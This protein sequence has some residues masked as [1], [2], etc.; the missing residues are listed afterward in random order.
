M[1]QLRFATALIASIWCIS[2]TSAT[3]L[4]IAFQ[5]RDPGVKRW[6]W[7]Q[8][9]GPRNSP[10]TIVYFS[11]QHFKTILGEYLVVLPP[12][13]YDIISSYTQARIARPDCP[14]SFAG[15]DVWY[16][17]QIAD[18]DKARTRECILPQRAACDY[19]SGVVKLRGIDWTAK[20][21][22]PLV[23]FMDQIKCKISAE[24]RS[25]AGFGR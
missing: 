11:T 16:T 12:A 7:Y 6:M 19:L 9:L 10:F 20:E 18:H 8:V 3:E 23:D 25:R 22:R 14:G 21:L 4:P 1:T 13:R 24:E 15:G 2:T 5:A 17:V